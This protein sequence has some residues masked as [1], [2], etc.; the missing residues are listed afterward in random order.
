[1]NQGEGDLQCAAAGSDGDW[2]VLHF[3]MTFKPVDWQSLP[4]S[5]KLMY[6]LKQIKLIIIV[7]INIYINNRTI[8]KIVLIMRVEK[9]YCHCH[10]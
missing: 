1:M 8:M 5:P 4:D 7:A 2:W 3:T 10:S 6:F 9:H